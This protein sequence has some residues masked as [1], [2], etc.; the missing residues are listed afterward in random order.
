MSEEFESGAPDPT[1]A[2]PKTYGDSQFLESLDPQRD[3]AAA[4]RIK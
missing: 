1:A 4:V 3:E 2:E